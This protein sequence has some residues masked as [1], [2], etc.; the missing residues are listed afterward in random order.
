MYSRRTVLGSGL[1]LLTAGCSS[2]DLTGGES[3]ESCDYRATARPFDPATE[4]PPD[5]SPA[6][7]TV[8][9]RAIHEGKTIASYGPEPLKEDSYVV[10]DGAY[11]EVYL[12][13]TRQEELP[14]LQM[15]VRWEAGQQ[16]PTGSTVSVLE[17]LPAV[18]QRALRSVVYGGLYRAHIHPETELTHYQ[19]PVPYPPGTA[20]SKLSTT[21]SS[22]IQLD[23]RYYAVH[24]H[25]ETTIERPI[26]E[27]AAREVAPD[28]D[29]FR[30]LVTER[31][32][33]RLD[34]LTSDE[35]KIIEKAING[36]YSKTTQS[37]F[38]PFWRLWKRMPEQTLP[39]S[40]GLFYIE[41]EGQRYGLD[42]YWACQGLRCNW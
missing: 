42:L 37:C 40:G 5:Y 12:V 41:Y 4:I 3:D 2:F 33:V 18:D 31:F 30:K 8:A 21:E 34:D 6:Q 32:L 9:E 20:R 39:E 1:A 38:S 17:D 36:E 13:D 27:Y 10:T 26:Y 25:G 19:S 16:V 28:A 35:Q 14:A 11:F 29:S 15:T 7:R 24:V 22:W 23:G